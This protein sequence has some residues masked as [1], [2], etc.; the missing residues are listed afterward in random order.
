MTNTDLNKEEAKKV[1]ET[2][3]L[4]A[5]APIAQED[6]GGLFEEGLADAPAIA[7][8]LEELAQDWQGRGLELVKVASGWRFQSRARMMP[9]LGRMQPERV[10]RYSRA[11]MEI[12]AVIAYR[13]PVTRGDIEEIR[14]VAVNSQI[15]R[16]LEERGWVE[17][18]GHRDSVGRPALFATTQKFLDDLGLASLQALPIVEHA[19]AQPAEH[20]AGAAPVQPALA[21]EAVVNSPAGGAAREEHGVPPAQPDA[22]AHPHTGH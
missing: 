17:V 19:S 6:L 10:P 4:C 2:A 13:Q 7:G 9:Y 5:G 20:A 3:L 18:V 1:L 16:Q 11:A 12:L 8:W 21:L 14:G 22:A 15:I